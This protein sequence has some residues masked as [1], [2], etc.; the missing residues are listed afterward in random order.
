[1]ADPTGVSDAVTPSE[2]ALVLAL[3]QHAQTCSRLW[4][5]Q[6]AL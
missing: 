1:M 5:T 6:M 3:T 4:L 2:T